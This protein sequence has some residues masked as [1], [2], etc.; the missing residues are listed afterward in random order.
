MIDYPDGE[1]RNKEGRPDRRAEV[2][3][4]RSDYPEGIKADC[5]RDLKIDRKTVSKYWDEVK[6]S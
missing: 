2:I 6:K 5:I 4:W 3:Q 1:W